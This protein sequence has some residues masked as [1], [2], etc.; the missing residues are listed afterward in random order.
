[1]E[2][3]MFFQSKTMHQYEIDF[4][5]WEMGWRSS[6]QNLKAVRFWSQFKSITHT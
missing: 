2:T 3:M 1:M 4:L 5:E 6:S